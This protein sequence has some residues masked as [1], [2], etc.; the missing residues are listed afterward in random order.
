[1]EKVKEIKRKFVFKRNCDGKY[2]CFA[3]RRI[4]WYHDLRNAHLF[5]HKDGDVIIPLGKKSKF[6]SVRAPG[7]FVP[8]KVQTTV[9]LI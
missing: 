8:V 9:D 7:K 5:S 6:D 2:L 4:D 1:M 3:W